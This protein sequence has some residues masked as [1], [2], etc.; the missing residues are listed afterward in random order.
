MAIDVKEERFVFLVFKRSRTVRLLWLRF[1]AQAA[2]VYL[3]Q[4]ACFGREFGLENFQKSL[5]IPTIL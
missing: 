4:G 2:Q 3:L 5:P 1:F